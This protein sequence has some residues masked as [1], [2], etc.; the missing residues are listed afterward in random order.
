[1]E[2]NLKAEIKPEIKAEAEA[3]GEVGMGGPRRVQ[4]FILGTETM[5]LN[6]HRSNSELS[7]LE[8]Q[9]RYSSPCCLT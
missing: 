7:E 4:N 8:V 5:N 1:V 9:M 3:V 2:V 6:S